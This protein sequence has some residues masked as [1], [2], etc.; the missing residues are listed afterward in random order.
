MPETKRATPNGAPKLADINGLPL[1]QRTG[2]PCHRR[3]PFGSYQYLP[4]ATEEDHLGPGLCE[5]RSGNDVGTYYC[6]TPS[7]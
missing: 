3:S 1:L 7:Y 6:T 5:N 2:G 4:T